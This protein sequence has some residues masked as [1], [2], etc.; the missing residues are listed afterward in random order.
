MDVNKGRVVAVAITYKVRRRII[1]GAEIFFF[2]PREII[3]K[4]GESFTIFHYWFENNLNG[5]GAHYTFRKFKKDLM[6]LKDIDY[7]LVFVLADKYGIPHQ[8][9]I[10]HKKRLDES[11]IIELGS[12]G[13]SRNVEKEIEEM[14]I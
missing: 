4:R 7:R 10:H 6:Y 5:S 12:K 13:R 2:K 1:D 9:T 14:F 8:S 3:L 11:E